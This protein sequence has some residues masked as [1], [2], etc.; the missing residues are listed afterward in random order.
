[1][2]EG[3]VLLEME[4]EII[5]DKAGVITGMVTSGV[6]LVVLTM[7]IEDVV[8]VLVDMEE[9]TIALQLLSVRFAFDTITLLLSA[10]IDSTRTLFQTIHPKTF[11]QDNS[12]DQEQPLWPLLRE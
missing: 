1:M 9:V 2:V 6:I 11:F 8:L 7:D 4:E 12:K 5:K 10:E 3:V